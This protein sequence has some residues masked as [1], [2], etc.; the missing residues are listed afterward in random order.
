M[1]K[2]ST[3]LKLMAIS[4]ILVI[5]LSGVMPCIAFDDSKYDA[6]CDRSNSRLYASDTSRKCELS[7][8]QVL[9]AYRE[10]IRELGNAVNNLYEITMG[11]EKDLED[12]TVSADLTV[13]YQNALDAVLENHTNV[14]RSAANTT[15]LLEELVSD[16][17]VSDVVLT[18]HLESL[19]EFE[20]RSANFI[21]L[22][23]QY[24]TTPHHASETRPAAFSAPELVDLQRALE[25]ASCSSEGQSLRGLLQEP[26]EMTAPQPRILSAQAE[27]VTAHALSR[28][29]DSSEYL[30]VN[31]SS[32][33]KKLAAD[34]QHDPVQIYYYVR[35]TTDFEPYFGLMAGSDWTIQ[36]HAG[37]SFDQAN[38]LVALL[39]ESG[40]PARYVYG[41][42]EVPE[43]EAAKWLRVKD[44]R[45]VSKLVYETGIPGATV[46]NLTE[47]TFW[48][49]LE[50]MW[51]EAYVPQNGSATWVAVDPS[52]K[53]YDY[54]PG[55]NLPYNATAMAALLTEALG[56]AS[57]NKEQGWV[58]GVNETLF[59][60]HF[61]A[62][63]NATRQAIM[64]DPELRN[65]TLQQLFGYWNLTT[66]YSTSLPSTLPYKVVSVLAVYAEIPQEYQHRI[67]LKGFINYTFYTPEI[68]SKKV[69]IK[70]N[71]ATEWD[72]EELKQWGWKN[73]A[74]YVDMQ[75]VLLI[76]GEPVATGSARA[77]GRAAELSLEFYQPLNSTPRTVNDTFTFGSLYALLFNVGTVSLSQVEN[78]LDEYDVPGNESF[79][80]NVLRQ[81]HLLGMCWFL[82]SDF[83]EALHAA[84]YDVR[85]YRSSPAYGRTCLDLQ[86]ACPFGLCSVDEGGMY[87]DVSR[88]VL[89]AVGEVNAS[90]AFMLATGVTASGLEHSIFKQLYGLDSVSTVKVLQEANRQGIPIY[91]ISKYNLD[92]RRSE[93]WMIPSYVWDWIEEEVNRDNIVIIPEREVPINGWTG[94]GYIAT[95]PET[96][97]F[98]FI[99]SYHYS[100]GSPTNPSWGFFSDINWKA[101]WDGFV[102]GAWS[103]PYNDRISEQSR[104]LGALLSNLVPY[105]TLVRDTPYYLDQVAQ[106]KNG[107]NL[108]QAVVEVIPFCGLTGEMLNNV[109][110]IYSW[111]AQTLLTELNGIH[112]QVAADNIVT[113]VKGLGEDHNIYPERY[114]DLGVDTGDEASE[115]LNNLNNIQDIPGSNKLIDQIAEGDAGAVFAAEIA[116]Q[117]KTE[118]QNIVGIETSIGG[119]A[120]SI[121]I[122][123]K[124]DGTYKV[125]VPFDINDWSVYESVQK[126]NELKQKISNIITACRNAYGSTVEVVFVFDGK[127]PQWVRDY[128]ASFGGTI[129]LEETYGGASGVSLEVDDGMSSTLAFTRAAPRYGSSPYAS[130]QEAVN[131]AGLGDTIY[132][133]SG[134]Y[135]GQVMVDKPLALIGENKGTTIIDGNG[136]DDVIRVITDDCVI[137]GFTVTNGSAGIYVASD[138]NRVNDTII[139][140]ITGAPGNDSPLNLTR[141]GGLGAGIYVYKGTNN[142]LANNTISTISGGAGGSFDDWLSTDGNGGKGTGIYL[143]LSPNTTV[144]NSTIS[145]ITGGRGG[146]DYGQNGTGNG[147]ELWCSNNTIIAEGLI[148]SNSQ[149]GIVSEQSYNSTIRNNV[150]RNNGNG[151]VNGYG[152]YIRSTRYATIEHNTITNNTATESSSGI[153]AES[154]SN[155]TISNNSIANNKGHGMFVKSAGGLNITGNMI[156]TNT[157]DGIRLED[158][159]NNNLNSNNI[160]FNKGYGAYLKSSS[161]N[162]L[163]DNKLQ[164]NTYNFGVAG[165]WDSDF[166]QDIDTSNTINGR[167]M[168]HVMGKSNITIDPNAGYVALLSCNNITVK[169]ITIT[170]NFLGML[171][172]NS[173]NIKVSNNTFSKNER[174][175]IYLWESGNNQVTANTVASNGYGIWIYGSWYIPSRNNSIAGNTVHSNTGYD[176]GYGIYLSFVENSTITSNRISNNTYYGIYLSSASGNTIC[177]NYFG[178]MKNALDFGTNRW[179][180]TRTPGTNIVGG[181]YLGGNYWSNYAGEDTDGD[182]LGNTLLPYNSAGWIQNGGDWL[183]LIKA[184]PSIFD[185]SEGSYPSISGTFTGTITPSR[186]LTVSTLYT[187]SCTGTGGH[188]KSIELYED[189]TLITSGVWS[190]Y[191]GDWHNI[192]LTEVTL[193]KDHEYRYVIV[194][195]SYPQIIHASSYNA[196]GGVITCTEFFDINGKRHEGWIPVVKLY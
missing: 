89:G 183:P 122:I 138:N 159:G 167:P 52:Y 180:I 63:V 79:A 39:R 31:A 146:G 128:L 111:G 47:G 129:G 26:A 196:T 76:D 157:G 117:S 186:N 87:I 97:E 98:G 154:V 12:G 185:T 165:F 120:A 143:Y 18:K 51:V 95:D 74:D 4:C 73:S 103:N 30:A 158:S 133:H 125:V 34:L 94:I 27:E 8:L 130:I 188:T 75:P 9:Q 2:K 69:M 100:G 108:L 171:V 178:N 62:Q 15:A 109:F 173:T 83:F 150:V 91:L 153:V 106:G 93:L 115:L 23:Q 187:Y 65:R 86:V 43:E 113:A 25:A 1:S 10:A 36:Q 81:L 45:Y 92:A 179:N 85:S 174:G 193:L 148:N 192:T 155:S 22:I 116:S 13:N 137:R 24:K 53:L 44:T 107:W 17:E 42:I 99:I 57:Y 175:G 134:T 29:Q 61:E 156:A 182:G 164:N 48:I 41:T 141:T 35:N 144:C 6:S 119:I 77:L 68:A 38:L 7:D 33:I 90:R 163:R 70:F 172:I 189:Q 190:G 19:E 21:H 49:Q 96:G 60:T 195:G 162:R 160:S 142:L 32:E 66:E 14:R 72:R 139:I 67:E 176:T 84:A 149:Y 191:Q 166:Y 40:I 80:D 145:G 20:V 152:V 71:P 123:M 110:N 151:S 102:F 37:N 78:E 184:E 177:N 16:G 11:L 126:Q 136:G 147:I 104:L 46:Y 54:V 127:V 3:I 101:F 82:E 131:A 194:T 88:Y 169:D 56:T 140:N 121:I 112:D 105:L 64:N 168:Y 55:L 118:G 132:V 50:H 124:Q 170:N 59:E 28:A 135:R 5:V 114:D 181:S 58:T 161:S